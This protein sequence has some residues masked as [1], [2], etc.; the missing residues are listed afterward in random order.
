MKKFLVAAVV[1]LGWVAP[2][3]AYDFLTFGKDRFVL[4]TSTYTFGSSV[5]STTTIL[6][7]LSST[8]VWPH[9]GTREININSIRFVLDKAASGTFAARIGVVTYVD[10]SSG[11]VT[12]FWRNPTALNV[13]NTANVHFTTGDYFYRTRVDPLVPVSVTDGAT[14]YIMSNEKTSLSTIYQ[15]D[16]KLPTPASASGVAPGVGD[17]V[18]DIVK[19]A[20][21][22]SISVEVVYYAE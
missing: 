13:S 7:D 21:S 6:V 3:K 10:V 16:V 11:S 14:P 20:S 17:I 5:T 15:T 2:V 8:T 9:K 12:W 18:L 22:Q 19:G 1:V 4:A